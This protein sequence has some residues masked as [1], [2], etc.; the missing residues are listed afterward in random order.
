MN[1]Y[2]LAVISTAGKDN[3]PEYAVIG[4]DKSL[5]LKIIFGTDNTSRKYNNLHLIQAVCLVIGSFDNKT[6]QYE[7]TAR[8]L[9]LVKNH[10]W[11]IVFA[12]EFFYANATEAYFIIKRT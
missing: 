6:V 1:K 4:F 2:K 10:Y 11:P 7:G 12:T 3:Q 5:E 8:E 9:Y